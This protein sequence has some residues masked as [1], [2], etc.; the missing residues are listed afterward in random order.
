[1]TKVK[2]KQIALSE[3][4]KLTRKDV[5][6]TFDSGKQYRE[7]KTTK[8]DGTEKNLTEVLKEIFTESV[9]P[10]AVLPSV[11]VSAPLMKAYEVGTQVSPAYAVTFDKGKYTLGESTQATDISA[12]SYSVTF[13]GLTKTEASGSFA[14]ITV[15]DGMSLT[16][17]A[18]ATYGDDNNMPVDNL[19][20][21]APEARIKG[22]TTA[23]AVSGALTGYRKYF[24]G[25]STAEAVDSVAVRALT[26]SNGPV[27]AGASVTFST[28]ESQK[29]AIVAAPKGLVKIAASQLVNGQPSDDI[30]AKFVKMEGSVL[31]ANGYDAVDY[32]I[33]VWQPDA[34]KATDIRITF[35]KT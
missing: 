23:T 6:G 19:G 18:T 14:A 7:V 5:A 10:T 24:Y 2:T 3:S 20:D 1:M 27:A 21:P 28:S 25:G 12:S 9:A 32:D 4:V 16:I 26:G 33:W 34:M 13:N 31:G 30:T 17:G 22:N 8:E 15:T 29:K 35:S 11:S